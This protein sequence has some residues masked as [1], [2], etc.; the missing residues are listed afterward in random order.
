VFIVFME[1]SFGVTGTWFVN[2]PPGTYLS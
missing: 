2:V 1:H